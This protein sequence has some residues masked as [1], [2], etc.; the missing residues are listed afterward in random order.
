MVKILSAIIFKKI[1]T[2][3]NEINI[4]IMIILYKISN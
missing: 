2:F 1:F 4:F 3:K